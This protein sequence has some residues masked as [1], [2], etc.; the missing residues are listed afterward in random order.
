MALSYPIFLVG[1][2]GCGKSKL[3]KRLSSR[4]NVPHLDLDNIIEEELG[5]SIRAFVDSHGE[6]AFRKVE[7]KLLLESFKDFKGIDLNGSPVPLND[8][9][10]AIPTLSLCLFTLKVDGFFVLDIK[11]FSSNLFS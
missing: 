6:E 11:L 8:P 2:M 9:D 3:A 5:T 10:Q 1:F 4:F 7:R